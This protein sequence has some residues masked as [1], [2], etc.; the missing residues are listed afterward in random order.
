MAG[1]CCRFVN[2]IDGAIKHLSFAAKLNGN[3]AP[4]FLA[5]G[6]AF[7]LGNQWNDA[8]DKFRRAIEIDPDH[9]LAYNSL[10]FTQK[11]CG[12]LDNALHNYD[13]GVKALVRRLVKSMRNNRKS[14]IF[15]HRELMDSLWVEYVSY[16][17]LYLASST[18]GIKSV[19]WL[20][21]AQAMEEEKTE[22]HAGLYWIDVSNENKEISRLF[23]PNYFNTFRELLKREAAYSTLIGNRGT[24][25]DLLGQ[26]DEAYKHYCE[27]NEFKP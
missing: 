6:M 1:Q 23:L 19:A 3:E 14:P 5:L 8:I 24:I 26:H 7:Q 17:A 2:D 4:I 25:L 11:K 15:K 10:A 21:G 18:D 22:K 12:Q 20:T 27:A 16:G 9:E 13:A